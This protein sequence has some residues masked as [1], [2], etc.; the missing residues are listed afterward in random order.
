VRVVFD[1]NVVVAGIVAQGLCREILETHLPAHTPLLSSGL[2]LELLRVM[3][4]K[5]DIDP[6]ALPVLAL[7]RRHAVWVEPE[8][9]SR[10]VCRDPDDDMVLA[11]AVSGGAAAIVTGD[12]DLLVLGS[13]QGVQIMSPREFLAQ[14]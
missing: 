3:T 6:A 13:Y 12:D 2:W 9:L 10:P 11:T 4:E 5:L 8:P 7:Y 1:T 14:K